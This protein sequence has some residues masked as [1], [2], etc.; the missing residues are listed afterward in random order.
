VYHL[1]RAALLRRLVEHNPIENVSTVLFRTDALRLAA[2]S[3]ET[4][5]HVGDWMVYLRML[6]DSTAVFVDQPLA[7]HRTHPDTTRVRQRSNAEW[8][9]LFA[10]MQRV[11]ELAADVAALDAKERAR[12][13][14]RLNALAERQLTLAERLADWRGRLV[15]YGAGAMGRQLYGWLR[16]ARPDIVV[17]FFVDALARTSTQRLDCCGLPVLA[18]EQLLQRVAEY[19]G[20][21]I[22][23]VAFHGEIA[24]W[25]QQ[26]GLNAKL[27]AENTAPAV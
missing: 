19:D 22:A 15:I 26:A 7:Q 10:E 24:A 5:K 21:L 23:S 9:V 12:A 25:L 16:T 1:D 17:P 14:A 2:P 6:R 8:T 13:H 20:I 18:P 3:I 4:F 11:T 27:V